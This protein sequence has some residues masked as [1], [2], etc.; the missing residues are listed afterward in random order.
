MKHSPVAARSDFFVSNTPCI[1]KGIYMFNKIN[2]YH[3]NVDA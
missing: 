1:I 3:Y 2:V